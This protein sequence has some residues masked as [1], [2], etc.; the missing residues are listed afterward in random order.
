MTK[1]YILKGI[2][3]TWQLWFQYLV[4]RTSEAGLLLYVIYLR[5]LW[6]LGY[7]P[8]CLLARRSGIAIDRA[9]SHNCNYHTLLQSAYFAV[10][11]RYCVYWRVKY[12]WAHRAPQCPVA[13][14][15]ETSWALSWPARTAA[16]AVGRSGAS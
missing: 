2:W 16:G 11:G 4:V 14:T 13:E 12:T 3:V 7:S 5:T 8:P 15:R 6:C 1:V 10:E 9:Y